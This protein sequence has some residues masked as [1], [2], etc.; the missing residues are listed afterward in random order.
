MGWPLPQ[1]VGVPLT[2]KP[3]VPVVSKGFWKLW[4]RELGF[5][6]F[7]TFFLSVF[8]CILYGSNIFSFFVLFF[9]ILLGVPTAAIGQLVI[10]G[11]WKK[12]LRRL[13]VMVLLPALTIVFALQADKQIPIN[14]TPITK[15]LESFREQT[16]HYPDTIEA[17][18]PKHLANIP[19]VRLSLVQ[20]QINYRVREGKP[21]LTIPSVAGDMFAKEWLR[22][23]GH[24][25]K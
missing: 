5:T 20:P 12:S 4:V 18:V 17:L 19:E 21:H 6:W 25:D 24:P 23:I 22:E 7:W 15:A 9:A 13:V 8:P 1:V 10:K 14:A 3:L 16:G 2:H 11:S